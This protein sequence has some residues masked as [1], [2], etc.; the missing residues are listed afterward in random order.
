MGHRL[1]LGYSEYLPVPYVDKGRTLDGW[2][3][4]GCYR[5]VVAERF[6]VV[7]HSWAEAYTSAEDPLAVSVVLGKR[8]DVAEWVP[9]PIGS[10][11]E[12]DGIVFMVG[13][14]PLH[15]GYI[16]SPGIMLH[17]MR[18]RGT[19]I[20]RYHSPLWQKRIEGIYRC[21]A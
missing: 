7:P 17:S 13:G 11:R 6:G 3:C 9:V 16:I 21:K 19:C 8:K 14:R 5:Y 10:E 18:G 12:G 4:Y 2:D 20:E 15:C 1:S